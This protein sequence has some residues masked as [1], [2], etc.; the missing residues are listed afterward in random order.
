MLITYICLPFSIMT[1]IECIKLKDSVQKHTDWHDS[2]EYSLLITPETNQF[3]EKYCLNPHT[4]D[5]ESVGY[6]CDNKF[7]LRWVSFF[8]GHILFRPFK[9]SE[10][11]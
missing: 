7:V 1:F 4:K 5:A 3:F 8:R 2:N 11:F 6:A 10:S 9:L